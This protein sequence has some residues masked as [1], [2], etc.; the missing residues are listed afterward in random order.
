MK[1][2]NSGDGGNTEISDE[3][4]TKNNAETLSA[5]FAWL[6]YLELKKGKPVSK[7]MEEQLSKRENKEL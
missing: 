2:G 7:I 4:V 1:E 3:Q 6:D 5:I